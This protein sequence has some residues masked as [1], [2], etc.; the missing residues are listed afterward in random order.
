MRLIGQV[1]QCRLLGPQGLLGPPLHLHRSKARRGV[2]SPFPHQ[3][4]HQRRD[5]TWMPVPEIWGGAGFSGGWQTPNT[6]FGSTL[7]GAASQATVSLNSAYTYNSAGNAVGA[8]LQLLSAKTIN[9]IYFFITAFGGTA[10]NVD[11]INVELRNDTS[12]KPGTT[13]HIS[14]TKN[15]SSTTGWINV[16]GLSFA[17]SAA[18]QYWLSVADADGNATDFATVLARTALLTAVANATDRT[19]ADTA[20]GWSTTTQ[21]ADA[22][23]FLLVFSDST[24]YGQPFTNT[25]NPTSATNRKGLLLGGLTEQ[26]KILGI[27]SGAAATSGVSGIELW[28]GSNGPGGTAEATGTHQILNSGNNIIGYYFDTPPTLAKATSYRLVLTFSASTALPRKM[29]I[30]TGADANL[31]AAMQGGGS[32]YWTEAN[33]T[34]DWSNDDTS[35]WPQAAVVIEDQVA[36]AGGGGPLLGPGRLV[37][38]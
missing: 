24:V 17:A 29:V 32:W 16:S 20:N 3:E 10:A 2:L 5:G 13:A 11:D 1:D 7:T 33:G 9:N 23:V 26:L 36:V 21:R 28:S 12:N 31:R 4:W 22:G 8:R 27:A 14:T 37:R 38:A 19:A 15:P 35:A 30:G 25:S 34:T 18:T 6:F